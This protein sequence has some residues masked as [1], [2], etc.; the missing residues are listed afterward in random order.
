M[1]APVTKQVKHS[2]V[3][4]AAEKTPSRK[5]SA[6]VYCTH[7]LLDPGNRTWAIGHGYWT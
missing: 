7:G 5:N 4:F 1:T 6:K 2:L 3:R